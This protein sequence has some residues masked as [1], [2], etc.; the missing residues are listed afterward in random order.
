MVD[1]VDVVVVVVVRISRTNKVCFKECKGECVLWD[2]CVVYEY[3]LVGRS[4]G[5]VSVECL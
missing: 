4:V 2:K 3:A 5:W 1:D